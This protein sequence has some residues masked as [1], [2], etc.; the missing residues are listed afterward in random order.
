MEISVTAWE[1]HKPQGTAGIRYPP[2]LHYTMPGGLRTRRE[3]GHAA[4]L[5]VEP[6]LQDEGGGELVHNA[7]AN[8]MA[9][10]WRVAG[11]IERSVCL[12][13]GEA[14]IPEVNGEVGAVRGRDVFA[15]LGRRLGDER[16]ELLNEAVD[17]LRLAAAVSREMKRI[18]Y[19]DAGAS[20]APCEAEDGTLIA[21]GLRALNGEERLRDAECVGERDTDAARADIETEPGLRGA[22]PG[23][24]LTGKWHSRHA[25][26]I[27]SETGS[28]D[29]NRKRALIDPRR[30]LTAL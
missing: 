22:P 25:L 11:G 20:V 17:T 7:R 9:F 12:G 24:R 29:Y 26:M 14:F 27:A 13:G 10:A 4:A 5:R 23:L 19:D 1:K 21:T 30:D 18:A 16:F 2:K 6:A 8:V 28:R 15:S 3:E